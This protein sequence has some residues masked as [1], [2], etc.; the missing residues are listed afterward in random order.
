METSNFAFLRALH[1]ELASL[2]EQAEGSIWL[3]PRGVLMQGRLF[4]EILAT[5]IS[6]QEKVEPVYSIKQID[7]LH[8]LSREGLLSEEIRNKFEWL[9]MNGNA[10]AHS[11]S[12]VHV[13]LALTAHRNMFELSAWFVELY[14]SVDSEVPAYQMPIEQ[15]LANPQVE[16]SPVLDTGLMEKVISDQLE[17]RLLPTLDEKFRSIEEALQRIAESRSAA[18]AEAI[19]QTESVRNPV[20][21]T[22]IVQVSPSPP[23]HSGLIEIAV[24][25]NRRNLKV[26]DKRPL[27]GALWVVGGWE[28]KEVLS[29]WNDQ[30]IYFRFAKNGSQ[31]T[32]RKPAW[33]MLGK[34]PSADRWITAPVIVEEKTISHQATQEESQQP[35]RVALKQQTSTLSNLTVTSGAGSSEE[36]QRRSSTFGSKLQGEEQVD[37]P[38][39]KQVHED[40]GVSAAREVDKESRP[41]EETGEESP[42]QSEVVAIPASLHSQSLKGYA[43]DRLTEIS[44]SLGAITFGDWNEERLMNLYEQ[45]PKLLHDVMVQLWFFGF[46]FE[47]KLGR[48]LKLQRD[49]NEG[50]IGTIEVDKK[51]DEILTPDVCRLLGR[52]GI[53][54][55]RQ[56]SGIP[57]S[58][59]A[60]L[61]RGRHGETVERLRELEA[62]SVD[63]HLVRTSEK[64]TKII[65]LNSE[66]LVIPAQLYHTP[67]ADL[68]IQGCNALLRG[69]QENWNIS[70]LGELPEVLTILPTRIK[71]VGM[72]T[73]TKFFEQLKGIVNA[74]ETVPFNHAVE[75]SVAARNPSVPVREAEEIVW[76][77]EIFPVNK[78]EMA[79][80]LETYFIGI[81]KLISELQNSGIST[82]GQL[83]SGLEQLLGYQGVGTTAVEKFYNQLI[84]MLSQYRVEQAE[85]AVWERMNSEERIAASIEQIEQTWQDWLQG[86]DPTRGRERNLEVL[87]FRWNLVREGRKVTLEETGQAFDLTRERIRQILIRQNERLVKD[88]GQLEKAIRTAC[89]PLKGFYYYPL[90]PKESFVHYLIIDILET[91]G[92]TYL[93]EYGWWSEKSISDIEFVDHSLHRTLKQSYKGEVISNEMLQGTIA[94][95]SEN[96]N[97]PSDLLFMFTESALLPC[98]EGFILKN[99]S[100]ADLVEM[101]LRGYPTGAEVY[102]K[103]DEL[104]EKAN[105]LWPNSFTKDRE[106]TSILSRDEYADTAYLWGRGVYIH[107]SFVEPDIALIEKVSLACEE[108]LEVRSPISIGRMYG[109]FEDL[110]QSSGVP[111]EYA[112]YTLLRKYGSSRLQL[113]KFPHIWHESDGFQLNNSDMLKGYIRELNRPVQKEDLIKEFVKNRGWKSFTVEFNLASDSDF[114]RVDYGV[115]GLRE[116]YYLNQSDIEKL[117]GKLEELLEGRS[118][119]HINLLFEEMKEFCESIDIHSSSLLY[120]LIQEFA[121]NNTNF[122]RYPFVVPAGQDIEKVN[123]QIL[124][125]QYIADQS[126]ELPVSREQVLQW[127]TEDLGGR[128]ES[129]D[130]ILSASKDI[131][132]YSRGQYGEYIHRES[133]GWS[134]DKEEQLLNLVNRRLQEASKDSRLYVLAKELLTSEYLPELKLTIEWSEDL[135][136]DLLKKSQKVLLIGSYDAILVSLSDSVIRGE[137][138]FVAYVMDRFFSGQ[139]RDR[140]L[141]RKLAELRF[142]KD[143]QLLYETLTDMESGKGRIVRDGDRFLLKD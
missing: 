130:I 14:G 40:T 123:M 9:R 33:F 23:D 138:D 17:A 95:L 4:G 80:P 26:I 46:Q 15:A 2:A 53:I 70:L 83:P 51:L 96:H 126:L 106:F 108:L 12:E 60:W 133:L 137:S 58:S 6:T 135:L 91:V 65:R 67:I 136:I 27:N 107:H 31:S 69:I 117:Y 44:N 52:F 63:P 48:F 43:S 29:T 24:E 11:S 47:G 77:A 34:N 49:S 121:A 118:I 13:D 90:Q 143:G 1:P 120:D 73:V 75:L 132:Y 30:G 105:R 125:E 61:L 119:L 113:R 35:I 88:T 86:Q 22:P 78:E 89:Q 37:L 62:S 82:V 36:E 128:E 7:R 109:Q 81:P 85:A 5:T 98:S 21:A 76:N 66:Q 140:D 57:V 87:R 97:V 32:K 116:F 114:V 18:A 112:L 38:E 68:N 101:V 102:K 134:E 50:C 59:L 110:L 55:T 103:A 8:K 3:N 19:V 139:V 64:V 16:Q 99:S 142:S 141:Y 71:S 56:L 111:N 124:I 129:L 127:L 39:A 20:L 84:H 25:L 93:E 92:L 54:G 131:I 94:I 115:I 100:K 72:T 104:M 122:I 74:G 45:Q 10:A 42:P 41:T 79:L 28:L